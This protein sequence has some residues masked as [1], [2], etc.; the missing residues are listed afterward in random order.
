MK[1]SIIAWISV[2]MLAVFTVTSV[3]AIEVIKEDK[4]AG[5]SLD[6]VAN[7][8][9]RTIPDAI[10]GGIYLDEEGNLVINT[11]ENMTT[12]NGLQIANNQAIDG[13]MI[14]K[15]VSYSMGELESVKEALEPYMIE[16]HIILLDADE[17]TNRVSVVFSER[18]QEDID[19]IKSIVNG[20]K[21]NTNM[22]DITI[23]EGVSFQAKAGEESGFF[24][25]SGEA[26]SVQAVRVIPGM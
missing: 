15:E 8:I 25:E 24:K 6:E 20:L 3:M 14:Y 7:Q 10:F 13:E 4:I 9:E 1:K 18:N 5:V 16:H 22:L 2:I 21:G 12:Q 23:S 26:K 17:I 11:T 19:A